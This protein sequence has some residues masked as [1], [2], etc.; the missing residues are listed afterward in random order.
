M[1]TPDRRRWPCNGRVA[2]SRLKG[3][4]VADRFVDPIRRHVAMPVADLLNA[5]EGRRDRQ[6]LYGEALD[7]L[8]E[9]DGWAFV[10]ALK[11]GY[12]GYIDAF[13]LVDIPDPTHRVSAAATHVYSE[14]DIKRPER[15][16]LSLGAL[17]EVTGT[18]GKFAVT[19]EGFIPTVHLSPISTPDADPV[20][21]SERLIGT[22]YLWG[23]NSRNG[24]DCSGLVQ[25]GCAACGI[26]CP[27]DSDMQA[28]ELGE[29]LPEDAVLQRGDLIF[30]KGHVAWVADESRIFHANGHD[31]STVYEGIDAAIARIEAQGDGKVTARRRL[32]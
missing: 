25:A 23:G 22:P 27:G 12:T 4:V 9:R 8:E 5:P 7:V 30:W 14:P 11:D 21:V 6:V 32:L 3:Q 10:E 15:L 24:I 26:P 19:P 17:V 1:S 16:A 2:S 29:A 28:R 13:A 20:A 31:M 18:E